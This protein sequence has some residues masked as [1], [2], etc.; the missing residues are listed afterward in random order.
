M[1]DVGLAPLSI[2]SSTAPLGYELSISQRL[3]WFGKRA[4]ETAEQ[5]AEARI[6]VANR[7]RHTQLGDRVRLAGDGAQRRKGLLGREGLATGEGLWI[8]P[9]EAV[10][11]FWM[12]FP[13]DLVYLDRQCRVVKVRSNV[14]PWRL[15]A[16]LRAHSIIELAAGTIAATQTKPGDELSMETI[17]L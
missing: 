16:C 9:C 1:L 14:G 7:T 13:I 12:R 11:T 5:A 3:P 8:L 4:L 2:G 17:H 15:S 6:M 10:H